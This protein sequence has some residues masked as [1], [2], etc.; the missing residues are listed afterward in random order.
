MTIVPSVVA[1]SST[2]EG[3][4]LTPPWQPAEFTNPHCSM[5]RSALL[6]L[7]C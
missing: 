3:A 5:V 7:L 1:P 2:L 4:S 6:S